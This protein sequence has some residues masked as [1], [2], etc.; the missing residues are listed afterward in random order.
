MGKV[1][2][3]ADVIAEKAAKHPPLEIEVGAKTITVVHP[4]LWPDEAL[5][6][7]EDA[8]ALAKVLLG[9]DYEAFR[10]AGGTAGVFA[11]MI[12]EAFGDVGKSSAS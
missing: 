3:L 2:K 11:E 5:A 7:A 9:K 6:V 10:K 12:G 1:Y 8:V 4:I